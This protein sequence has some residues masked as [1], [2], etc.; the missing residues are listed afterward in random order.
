M[1]LRLADRAYLAR[2]LSHRAGEAHQG[3]HWL[4]AGELTRDPLS[5]PQALDQAKQQGAR[6]VL[7]GIPEDIG[8][9]ANLGRGGADLAW[10]AF[11]AQF[12]NLQAN[13]FLGGE[14]MLL[15]GEVDT[16]SLQ[17][18][19]RHLSSGDT[20]QL[21]TLRQLTEALDILVQPLIAQVVAAGLEPIVIGGGHNNAY[22]IL[23]GAS[24]ALDGP[25]SAVNL[26]P[27]S[28]FRAAEGRHSGNGFAYAHEQ[29]AL[30]YY[31]V[32]GLHELK[33]NSAS[34]AALK[35]GDKR[36]TSYQAIWVRRELTLAQ[37]LE[38]ISDDLHLAGQPL[39]VELDLDAVAG[40]ASSA[41]T[42]AGVPLT[43]AL[44]SV[45]H[46]ARHHRCAYLHLAEGA[47]ACHP[48][49]PEAG[50]RQIGQALSEL[51]FSYL[52]GRLS[53]DH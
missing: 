8:P 36:W 47:P 28:D 37:A 15:L 21:A 20:Q 5:L 49:G 11:L 50:R 13:T 45:Y 35:A 31:H 25:L 27:H 18:Q 17:Q 40:L 16:R 1:T 48:A 39:G 3:E 12:A 53:A 6:Y 29:G 41:E 9:R 38:R 26:D 42:V 33:N 32:L 19:A 22:P 46:L 34:L 44:H 30:G 14:Q 10:H 23:S 4:L 51:V 52:S 2:F 24:E 7:L 43:D